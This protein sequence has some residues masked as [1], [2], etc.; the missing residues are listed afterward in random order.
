MESP[1]IKNLLETII[2][3]T[4][5][6]NYL[7]ANR[8]IPAKKRKN[9][10]QL[11]FAAYVIIL[12]IGIGLICLTF[13]IISIL[14]QKLLSNIFLYQINI[15]KQ[16][17][18]IVNTSKNIENTVKYYLPL[19][20]KQYDYSEDYSSISTLNYIND[21]LYDIYNINVTDTDI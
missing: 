17:D 7:N 6:T 2:T 9:I 5:E 10:F 21:V 15:S 12:L 19:M 13:L 8:N 20:E 4:I 18:E 3:K 1:E 16:L 14:S 11:K